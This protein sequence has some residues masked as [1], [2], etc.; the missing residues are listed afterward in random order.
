MRGGEQNNTKKVRVGRAMRGGKSGGRSLTRMLEVVMVRNGARRE[1]EGG[2]RKEGKKLHETCGV[3]LP[4]GFSDIAS[5]LKASI[6]NIISS[7]AASLE[8]PLS[9]KSLSMKTFVNMPSNVNPCFCLV[10]QNSN[11]TKSRCRF[12][13]CVVLRRSHSS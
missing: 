3:S 11:R 2:L 5:R 9:L 7:N 8:P 4:S 12:S 6:P 10:L 13:D 1:H